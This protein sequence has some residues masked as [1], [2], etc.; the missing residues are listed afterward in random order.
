MIHLFQKLESASGFLESIGEA[1]IVVG[2]GKRNQARQQETQAC[3]LS[4]QRHNNAESGVNS[5]S[6]HAACYQAPESD[7]T[8]APLFL[9]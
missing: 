9:F 1:T 7:G 3:P 8:D 6:D 2:A 4:G 5:A